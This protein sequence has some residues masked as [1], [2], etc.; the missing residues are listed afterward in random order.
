MVY[1]SIIGGK[2]IW[3]KSVDVSDASFTSK[4]RS[5]IELC[6]FIHKVDASIEGQKEFILNQ[7]QTQGDYYFLIQS[8]DKNPLGTIALYHICGTTAEIGRWVSLGNAFENL[9]SIILVHD[10]AFNTLNLESVYTCTDVNNERVKNF[11]MRFGGDERYIE[12]ESD[13]IA[14]K[15]IVSKQTYYSQIRPKMAKL[16]AIVGA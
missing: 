2:Y 5:N 13:Y 6:K 14:S 16:L 7:R 3:L 15:N 4:L 8:H 9:E 12:E 1:N 10:F 11:W